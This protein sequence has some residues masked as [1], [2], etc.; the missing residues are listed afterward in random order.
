MTKSKPNSDIEV[1]IRKS[2]PNEDSSTKHLGGF[3]PSS[4]IE[5]D[6]PA[7][8]SSHNKVLTS[9]ILSQNMPSDLQKE[10][11]KHSR[12]SKNN[13]DLISYQEQHMRNMSNTTMSIPE[14]L[15]NRE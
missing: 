1:A 7:G 14:V 13:S 2:Q 8:E 12:I 15:E 11:L 4:V 6:T 3:H 5:Q 9:S 10:L